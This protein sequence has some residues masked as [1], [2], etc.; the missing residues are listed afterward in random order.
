MKIRGYLPVIVALA[1]LA[2]LLGT[3][4]FLARNR[5]DH[6]EEQY[7][8]QVGNSDNTL[9][10]FSLL[11]LEIELLKD[12]E[13]MLRYAPDIKDSAQAMLQTDDQ[14]KANWVSGREATEEIARFLDSL[15]PLINDQPLT[16]IQAIL[17][18]WG[19]KQEELTELELQYEFADGRARKIQLEIDRY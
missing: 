7:R 2:I 18:H 8:S 17:D 10:S 14:R 5:T 9:E 6:Q 12:R 13:I 3:P 1:I 15:P 11:K 16:L 19:L 4:E